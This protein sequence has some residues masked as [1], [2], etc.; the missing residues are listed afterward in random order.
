MGV[1]MTGVGGKPSWVY[2]PNQGSVGE[3]QMGGGA[4]VGTWLATAGGLSGTTGLLTVEKDAKGNVV[5]SVDG[6]V[7]TTTLLTAGAGVAAGMAN[8]SQLAGPAGA[9]AGTVLG[10]VAT[11]VTGGLKAYDASKTIAKLETIQ[12]K[13]KGQPQPL[14]PDLLLVQ[15]AITYCLAKQNV[16][17]K[18]G[19]A[20]AALVGQPVVPLVR[21][22]KAVSK[23]VQ[24]TK[25][26]HRR[27]CAGS[28]VEL[29]EKG[30]GV[31]SALAK[32][33]IVAIISM[34]YESIMT[35]ALADAMKTD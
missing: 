3:S 24:G 1:E 31:A 12:T 21:A 19:V 27:N 13:L 26:V 15:D 9:V 22:G 10:V 32:E 6:R 11:A 20:N 4:A 5:R 14:S 25:G 17:F 8:F 29:S 28:L 18:K 7:A 16:K 35:N 33:I 23:F 30:S 34:N 2:D